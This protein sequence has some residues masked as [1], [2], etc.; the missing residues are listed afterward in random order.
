MKK[1][2][3][4]FSLCCEYNMMELNIK[5]NANVCGSQEIILS[6]L[7]T[8]LEVINWKEWTLLWKHS[9]LHKTLGQINF[10]TSYYE[11][12]IRIACQTNF[13]L[14]IH[15]MG[16]SPKCLQRTHQIYVETIF[17]LLFVLGGI[18]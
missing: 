15:R 10:G 18:I 4:N 16:S 11:T 9:W 17:T 8:C 12:A 6:R 2:I 1:K 14:W 7:I 13:A 5:K 3:N